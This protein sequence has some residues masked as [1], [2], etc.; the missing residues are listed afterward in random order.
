ME[1][2]K[3]NEYYYGKKVSDYALQNGYVDYRTLSSVVGDSVLCN[4]MKD[5]LYITMDVEGSPDTLFYIEYTEEEFEENEDLK[6]EYEDYYDYY[7][8]NKEMYDIFQW[9]IISYYGAE[10]LM[11]N[12]DELVFYDNE[13]DVYVWGITHYDTG[14][15]Y[16][17]TDIK[18]KE[19]D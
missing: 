2:K 3:Y 11:H 9:Y 12:T 18:L 7:E 10:F 19:K 6:E 15:D 13:L 8:C 16:V 1:N 4:A 14:W 17:L 5:R